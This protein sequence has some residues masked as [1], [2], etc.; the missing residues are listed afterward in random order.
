MC[1]PP[2]AGKTTLAHVAAKH[3]GY[4]PVEINASDERSGK[5]LKRRIVDAMEMQS[6][7]GEKKAELYNLR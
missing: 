2:G 7:F 6:M 1:G 4:K 5:S 3:A